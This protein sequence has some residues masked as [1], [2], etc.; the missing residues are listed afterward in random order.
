MNDP[1][2]LKQRLLELADKEY[3]MARVLDAYFVL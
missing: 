2:T 1:Y 3:S